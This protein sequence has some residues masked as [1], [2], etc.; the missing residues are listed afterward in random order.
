M[1][2]LVTYPC[3][4]EEVERKELGL[5]GK[6]FELEA[7]K[8][9]AVRPAAETAVR[10]GRAETKRLAKAMVLAALPIASRIG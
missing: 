8:L 10:P 5:Y 9:W 7:G 3:I 2:N 1:A 4:R 6:R